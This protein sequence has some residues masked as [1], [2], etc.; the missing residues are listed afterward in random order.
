MAEFI[1]IPISRPMSLW[2]FLVSF[3]R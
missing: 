1:E 3:Q 2:P